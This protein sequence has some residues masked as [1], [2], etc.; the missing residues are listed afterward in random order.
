MCRSPAKRQSHEGKGVPITHKQRQS[1]EGKGVPITH[2]QRQSREGKA[3][4]ASARYARRPQARQCRQAVAD[5]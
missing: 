3:L 5:G 1:R 4:K 2:K